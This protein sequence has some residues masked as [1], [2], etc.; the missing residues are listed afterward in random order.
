[1]Y[2]LSLNICLV[3]VCIVQAFWLEI[4]RK[5]GTLKLVVDGNIMFIIGLREVGHQWEECIHLLGVE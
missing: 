4:W 1:M 3:I 2:R 5:E